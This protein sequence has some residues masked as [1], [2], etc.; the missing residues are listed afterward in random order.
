MLNKLIN[1]NN[2][3]RLVQELNI[4]NMII[5]I[6]NLLVHTI[7]LK[8]KYKMNLVI[9]HIHQKKKIINI[10]NQIKVLF[11]RVQIN[12]LNQQKQHK[13]GVNIK[14]FL[15]LL[16]NLIQLNQYLNLNK[17]IIT[18]KLLNKDHN[19]Q[20]IFNN[21][22]HICKIKVKKYSLLFHNYLQIRK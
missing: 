15:K 10:Y 4:K 3:I 20:R 11:M 21:N 8:K 17:N 7:V 13:D 2:Q 14:Q 9:L 1:Q 16:L 12:H 19:K 22:N 18:H 6:N 5:I